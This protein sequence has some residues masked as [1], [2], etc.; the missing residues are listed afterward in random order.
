MG[1]WI[2][3]DLI[4]ENGKPIE[5]TPRVGV[6]IETPLISVERKLFRSLPAWECGLKHHLY[7]LLKIYIR[8]TPRV[9][10]WIE[11][12]PSVTP[13]LAIE[14][15]PAWECG[16]KR[17]VVSAYHGFDLCHSPRGSVD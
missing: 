12:F 10:V 14:S 7:K 15:L 2:E 9:G 17:L 8:V 6:W 1:V 5:V 3:T 11:T 4:K 16:L 13:S